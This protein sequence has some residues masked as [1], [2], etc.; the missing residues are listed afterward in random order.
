MCACAHI[1]QRRTWGALIGAGAPKKSE[2]G[3]YFQI[4]TNRFNHRVIKQDRIAIS[5]DPDQISLILVN[6][7]CRDLLSDNDNQL[8]KGYNCN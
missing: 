3:N 8:G 5:V 6:T 1:F 2:Y 4:S 7:I